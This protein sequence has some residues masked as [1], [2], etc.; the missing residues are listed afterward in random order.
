M[1][2]KT[3]TL[4]AVAVAA[5]MG[6]SAN[7]ALTV[8]TDAASFAAA[9]T[10]ASVDSF[11]DLPPGSPLDASLTRTT[12]GYTYTVSDNF[13]VLYGAGSTDAWLSNDNN[14]GVITFDSF[15]PN[16]TAIG[17]N[18]FGSDIFGEFTASPLGFAITAT[19]SSGSVTQQLFDATT[20]SFV[21][22]TTD[23]SLVSLSIVALA[24]SNSY[25]ATVNNL[26]LAQVATSAVPEPA[27]WALMIGG[28]G[29]VGGAMRRR[30]AKV[31]Y[32]AA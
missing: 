28:F 23:S 17:A 4:A 25:W 12:G 5:L 22:F 1:I 27:A 21:G 19:D 11:D 14:S 30:V 24:P 15:S 8:Y 18:F 32:A 13:S 20:S 10:G 6:S 29:L 31:G 7:A 2:V 26:T 3:L 9:T 16:L